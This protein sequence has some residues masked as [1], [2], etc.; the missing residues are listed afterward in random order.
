MPWLSLR[1]SSL[2]SSHKE[3]ISL[4]PMVNRLLT[5]TVGKYAIGELLSVFSRLVIKSE[6]VSLLQKMIKRVHRR[7]FTKLVTVHGRLICLR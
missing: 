6:S 1:A 2:E 5:Y 4:L 7:M 3:L